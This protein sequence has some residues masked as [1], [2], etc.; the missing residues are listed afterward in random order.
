VMCCPF[1]DWAGSIGPTPGETRRPPCPRRV[2]RRIRRVP[3][4]HDRGQPKPRPR[5]RTPSNRL[6][7]A[8][9]AP[10]S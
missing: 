2:D 4:G 1:E 8:R 10:A 3:P 9:P 6:M 5:S 7:G